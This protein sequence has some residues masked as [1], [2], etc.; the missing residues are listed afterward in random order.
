MGQLKTLDTMCV[1][2]AG[3]V[4]P[5]S[6]VSVAELPAEETLPVSSGELVKRIAG[7]PR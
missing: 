7:L 5:F 3:E 6:A 1:S 4:P 2:A